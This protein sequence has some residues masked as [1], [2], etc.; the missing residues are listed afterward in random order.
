MKFRACASH[1]PAE[2]LS[3]WDSHCRCLTW[4]SLPHLVEL[5]DEF[6]RRDLFSREALAEMVAD[7]RKQR[8]IRR[9]RQALDLL[10]AC[11]E[12]PR[13]S[14]TR[15]LLWE[16]GLP[17]PIPNLNIY[18]DDGAFLARGDLVYEDLRVILEYDGEHHL[19]RQ[20]QAS[21]ADRRHKLE[22]HGW[23]VVTIVP[24][25][26][27]TPE[28]LGSKVHQAIAHRRQRRRPDPRRPDPLNGRRVRRGCAW[29]GRRR[30]EASLRPG[31]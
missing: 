7:S 30:H 16:G 25:D 15:V 8:G 10:D 1:R 22:I 27:A 31:G 17:A 9:V 18:D 4:S 13:E 11:S 29:A 21:D 6:L 23:M 12:S 28:R 5:G 26:L 20:Q 2:R 19:A 24:R 14:I 3:I